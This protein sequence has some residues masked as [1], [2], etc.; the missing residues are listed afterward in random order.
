[1]V[2]ALARVGVRAIK[3]REPGGAPGAEAIRTLLVEGDPA[4]W[5]A[6]SE[7]LLVVAARRS[8]LRDTVWPALEAGAWVVCDRFADSTIAY[9]GYGG[10]VPR[11]DLEVLHRIIAGDFR[12]D[13]TLILD[14]PV[15]VGIARATARS[16]NETR[17]E[18]M[19]R[20]FHERLRR[21]FLE[22]AASEPS[23]CVMI[24]A[25]GSVDD[26]HRAILTALRARFGLAL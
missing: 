14:L 3:T 12:P 4:R 22:I 19:G 2:E 24:D 13:V 1:L 8:H 25:Q 15:E 7:A 16:G 10:G 6:L 17:F 20:D 21:G 23:R 26:V 5:D 9:Q 11:A 18:K